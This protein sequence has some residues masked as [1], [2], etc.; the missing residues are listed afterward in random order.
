MLINI[1]RLG[2]VGLYPQIRRLFLGWTCSGPLWDFAEKSSKI[3]EETASGD[4][5]YYGKAESRGVAA[6]A[7]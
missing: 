1:S 7:A 3:G 4:G 2:W 5:G 6:A